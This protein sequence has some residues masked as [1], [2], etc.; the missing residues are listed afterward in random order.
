MLTKSSWIKLLS[1][2]LFVG[3]ISLLLSRYMMVNPLPYNICFRVA[4]MSFTAQLIL[5]W[6]LI[7]VS[8]VKD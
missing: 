5:G 6:L 4:G 8:G 2:A 1:S 7:K 3:E